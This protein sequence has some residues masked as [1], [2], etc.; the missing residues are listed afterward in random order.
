MKKKF[1]PKQDSNPRLPTILLGRDIHYTIGLPHWICGNFIAV[2]RSNVANPRD[3]FFVY[4]GSS[5][6]NQGSKQNIKG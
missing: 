6:T 3:I 1:C 2:S 4:H 5:P